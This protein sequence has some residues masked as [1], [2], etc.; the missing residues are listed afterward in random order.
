M[1]IVCDTNVLVSGLL[2]GGNCRLIIALVSEGRV[3][4]FTSSALL[5]ELEG[6]LLRPKFCLGASQVEAIIDLVRQTFLS[7]APLDAVMAVPD[8]PDD[9]TVL[10]VAVAAAADIVVSGD[11]HLLRLGEFQGIRIV[12][13]ACMIEEM[14]GQHLGAADP[15]ASGGT[16]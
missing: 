5:A 7:V 11:D 16:P 2:F 15:H 4:G 9:D 13:P 8:D 1:R 3:D 12:S 10:E 14:R 6:V